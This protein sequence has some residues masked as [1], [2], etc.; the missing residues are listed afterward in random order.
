MK[1]KQRRIAFILIV[2]FL[3]FFITAFSIYF[4]ADSFGAVK[5][6]K[7]GQVSDKTLNKKSVYNLISGFIYYDDTDY[8]LAVKHLE[9]NIR[10]ADCGYRYYTLSR[11]YF[12]SKQYD[13]ALSSINTALNLKKIR[14][15]KKV[16]GNST[17]YLMLK[18]RILSEDNN[19]SQSMTVLK[20]ILKKEPFNLNALL[21]ISKLYIYKKDFKTAILYLNIVKL[22]YPDN[23]DAYYILSKIYTA[24]NNNL[25]AERNLLKLI[26]LD[27]YFKKGYFQLSAMYILSG[28]AKM[29]IQ[30]FDRYL[31]VDPYSKTALYQLGLLNYALKNYG[32]AR[33]HFFNFLNITAKDKGVSNFRNNALFFIG[34]SY[35][36]QKEYEKG[37]VYLDRLKYGR[38]YVDAKLE[39]IEI[40]LILYKK[41]KNVRYGTKVKDII[42]TLLENPKLKKD[43][44]VYYFSA[45]ALAEIKNF[46]RAKNVIKKG[47][48][49]FPNSTALMYELGSSYHSLK[50]NK[51]ANLVM[52]NILRIDPLNAQALNYIGY[53]LAMRNKNSD[54]LKKAKHMIKKALAADKNSPYI[55]DSLGFVYY[56]Y[57]E[58]LKAM[59]CF[60]SALK[61][62]D[63]SPTVLKHIGMTYFMLKNYNKA[64]KYFNKSY[65]IKKS[66]SV[67]GYVLKIKNINTLK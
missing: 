30:I 19:I 28:K 26:K 24:E 39:E 16:S 14:K 18:A 49:Y 25:M 5:A 35:I 67:K 61:K 21:F 40:Y 12:K 43:I 63:K 20:F 58:Y 13:K 2:F 36:L 23:M 3:F 64:I 11:A 17:R 22:N 44:K 60:K 33:K 57:K 53:Y 1:K 55:L 45:I 8:A 7:T 52:R 32:T 29:A 27:P 56:R 38:H 46:T 51:K 37:L 9:K 42:S 15:N 10:K 66:K 48:V 62:L 4:A 54:D 34:I 47:L 31:K 50:E 6:Q 65:S 59:K 41:H